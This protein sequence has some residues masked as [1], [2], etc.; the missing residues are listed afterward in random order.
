MSETYPT[1]P[2][3]PLEYCGKWIAWDHER[4][5]IVASADSLAEVK[6]SA[7]QVGETKPILAKAPNA[8]VRFV[9]GAR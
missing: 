6:E 2:R 8:H 1:A 4:T 3:V 5:R 7:R 9:G